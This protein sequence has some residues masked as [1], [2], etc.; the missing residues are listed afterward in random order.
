[1]EPGMSKTNDEGIGT[2][3]YYGSPDGPQPDWRDDDPDDE[4]DD[5][6][7]PEPIAPSVLEAMLGFDP[8]ED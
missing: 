7:D 5:D 1:M 2:D 3:L 4:I 6:D 8:A